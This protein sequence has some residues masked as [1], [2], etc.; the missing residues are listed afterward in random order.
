MSGGRAPSGPVLNL[1]APQ[2]NTLR[3]TG[4]PAYSIAAYSSAHVRSCQCSFSY[5]IPSDSAG[6]DVS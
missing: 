1:S 5:R 6:H 3:F 4:N 2:R